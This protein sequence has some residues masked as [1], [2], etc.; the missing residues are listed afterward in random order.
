VHRYTLAAFT[1]RLQADI[2]E[3]CTEHHQPWPAQGRY[4][5]LISDGSRA[6]RR[7]RFEFEFDIASRP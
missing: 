4:T 7:D 5:R 3:H 6:E 1:E 2:R